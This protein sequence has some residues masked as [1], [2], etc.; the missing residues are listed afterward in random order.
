MRKD[1][2]RLVSSLVKSGHWKLKE[3]KHIKIVHS[4]GKMVVT[5][6]TPSDPS[7]IRNFRSMVQKVERMSV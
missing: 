7:A 3:G 5:S 6:R 4:S 2:E 1:L